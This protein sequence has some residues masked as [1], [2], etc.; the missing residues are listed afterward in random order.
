M[1][2]DGVTIFCEYIKED[3][4][5]N[6]CAEIGKFK[7]KK[8]STTSPKCPDKCPIAGGNFTEYL[9]DSNK[10]IICENGVT[11]AC[12]AC[13][14]GYSFNEDKS[15]CVKSKK[16]TTTTTTASPCPDN[17]PS[18]S[19]GDGENLF[20]GQLADPNNPQRYIVCQ[21]GVTLGCADCPD[22]LT[23]NEEQSACLFSGQE[24]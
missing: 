1:C 18:V 22:G 9:E 15:E 5:E 17:C 20:S 24:P 6:T 8:T 19:N 14:D 4:N 13:P 16:L 2:V 10:L 3:K 12:F 7:T 11:L 23:F 21:D